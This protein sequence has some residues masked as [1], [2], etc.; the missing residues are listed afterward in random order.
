MTTKF[1]DSKRLAAEFDLREVDLKKNPSW[2]KH[3]TIDVAKIMIDIFSEL[4][5]KLTDTEKKEIF[6]IYDKTETD[7]LME[8]DWV[9]R[10]STEL[11]AQMV[12]NAAVKKIIK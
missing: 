12:I 10:M 3:S 2:E 8:C 11:I 5:V 7:Y 6:S 1:L 9:T 4:E